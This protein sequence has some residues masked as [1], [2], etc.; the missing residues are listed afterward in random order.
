MTERT[1]V[2][3]PILKY[4]RDLKWTYVSRAEAE[5]RRGFGVSASSP[6]EACRGGSLFFDDLLFEKVTEFNPKLTDTKEELLL[7]LNILSSSIQGNRDFLA[8]LRGQKQYFCR[9][10]NREYDLMLIDFDN[11]DRNEY[12][13]TEEYYYHNGRHGNR[14]DIVFLINGIPVLVIECKNATKEEAIALGV[15]QLRRYHNET[16]EMMVPPQMFTVTESLGFA[17]GVTWNIVRRSIFNWKADEIGNLEDKIKTFCSKK[18]LLIYL[19]H[20]IIFSEKD[21]ELKKYVLAQH[22]AEAVEL[23]IERIRN[24]SKHRGLVWHTQGSGK[25]FT[26]IKI[27][28]M[29]FKAPEFEKPTVLMLIDRNE[30]E[31]Q[32]IRNL[33][34]VGIDHAEPAE[35]IDALTDLLRKD[36]RGIIVSTI[37]KFRDM[38]ANINA[39]SNIYVLVDEAHRTTQGDLG[40]FLMAAIPNATFLGFTGTP[41][42]KTAY[43]LGTFKTFG[44]DDEPRGYLHKYSIADSIKDCTTLPLFYSLAPNEMLVDKDVLETEFLQLAEAEGISDIDELNRILERTATLRTFLKGKKRVEKIAQFVAE[45][46]QKNVEPLGY[47][48]FMV[49]VDREACALYKKALDKYL[50]A[51]YSQIVFTGTNNDSAELKRHHISEEQEKAIRKTFAKLDTKPKILIVTEK[52]LTGFDAPILYAM[53]LD[54]PMRDHTL[55]QAIARVNRPYENEER[56]MKKPHG[57]V[58]DFIGIFDKLEKALAFDS[59]EVSSVIKDIKLLKDLFKKRM[60]SEVRD[61]VASVSSP[62]TDKETNKL[63]TRFKDKAERKEFFKCYKEV[64]SLYEIISPDAFLRPYLDAYKNLSEMYLVVRNAFAKRTYVD[65]EFL[66]KTRELIKDKVDINGLYGGFEYVTLDEKGLKKI[67]DSKD[68]DDV[69]VINL[70]KSIQKDAEQN[71]GD[72]NLISLA[73]KAQDIEEDYENKQTATQAALEA[74]SRLFQAEGKRKQEQKDKGFDGLTYFVYGA[75]KERGMAKPEETARKIK[76]CFESFPHWLTSEQ[77]ERDLRMELYGL[78]VAEDDDMDKHNAFVDY[79]FDLL[80][81]AKSSGAQA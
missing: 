76:Q 30:L 18:Q 8:F 74:L 63:V 4:A 32:L 13:V 80:R 9:A 22:Q 57:F 17:Y 68:G 35:S 10:E 64:E 55:L 28:E 77:E 21:E 26:M 39:R 49:G 27:A 75:L 2:Q 45:H 43:G 15:D 11:P 5:K 41:I 70:I 59:E 25:T 79:L 52:L 50:P 78:L 53:Y 44:I 65:R 42:D 29:V 14:E 36:F 72:L 58:L 69:K 20:Y 3:N 46:Y 61:Y 12:H 56:N 24:A 7:K 37:H 23:A 67:K 60:E 73:E 31:D 40:N 19:R 51:D 33:K 6:Q 1:A 47:K 81:M 16:P 38:P 48:A 71:S 54:K 62:I 66:R 34:N